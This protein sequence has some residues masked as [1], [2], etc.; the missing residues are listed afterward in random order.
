[1][2]TLQLYQQ[3]ALV[4]QG[5]EQELARAR[6]LNPGGLIDLGDNTVAYKWDYYNAALLAVADLPA[7]SPIYRDYHW[8]G[9]SDFRPYQHQIICADFLCLRKKAYCFAGTGTGKTAIGLWAAHYLY[10]LGLVKK[11]LILCPS[12]VLLDAWQ[13]TAA[14]LL[15][16]EADFTVIEGTVKQKQ[17]QVASAA[18]F[19]ITNYEALKGLHKKFSQNHY[20]LI[21]LDESTKIKNRETDIWSLVYPLVRKATYAWQMTGTPTPMGPKDAFGQICMFDG[22][23]NTVPNIYWWENLTTWKKKDA[24]KRFPL[25]GWQA[26]VAKY[27]KPALRIRTRD[28]IDLPPIVY[29]SRYLPLTAVQKA[30]IQ[31]LRT[32]KMVNLAGENIMGDNR[33]ILL[34]KVVQICCGA[35]LS[36]SGEVVEMKPTKRLN[37]C[38]EIIHSEEGKV[39]I[40]APFRAAVEMITR[41]LRSK[42]IAVG[43]IHG[44][45]TSKKARQK[46]FDSF[47]ND[48][49]GQM[50]VIVGV[51][52]AFAH[53]VTLTAA[54]HAIWY[55]PFA[56]TEVYLQATARME[57]NG[58]KHHMTV[59]EMWGDQRE[60]QLYDII[61]G[62]AEAQLTLLDIYRSLA[63]DN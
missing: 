25:K 50:Q 28:C 43:V 37:E 27:M 23:G 30:A 29:E 24:F 10:T 40:F 18:P 17:E 15:F 34:D 61:A 41:Y 42:N 60:K 54:S 45:I 56:S 57:R 51:P 32:Q 14:K 21:I 36:E 49:K 47:Q 53:G 59:T 5:T 26:T 1:M 4:I 2:A 38:L 62:R 6:V 35:V 55:A 12:S 52:S 22:F 31:M 58:Q 39:L 16:G 3:R 48:L 19:H 7:V 33:A 20:D 46:I 13:P 63:K 44:G 9:P 11:I 8:P